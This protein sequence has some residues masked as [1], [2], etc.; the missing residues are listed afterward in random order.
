MLRKVKAKKFL[1]FTIRLYVCNP[2]VS[3]FSGACFS[4]LYPKGFQ[5]KEFFLVFFHKYT[6]VGQIHI[7]NSC[8]GYIYTNERL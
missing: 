2:T 6:I 1:S 5:L 7:K 8:C 4:S 3:L